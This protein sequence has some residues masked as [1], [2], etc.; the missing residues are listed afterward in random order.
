MDRATVVPR[1]DSEGEF[2]EGHRELTLRVG[3]NAGDSHRP[4]AHRRCCDCFFHVSCVDVSLCFFAHGLADQGQE[5]G[6]ACGHDHGE[7]VVTY[8]VTSGWRSATAVWVILLVFHESIDQIVA[9]PG[10]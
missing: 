5:R 9:Q 3:V 1:L 7:V 4:G 10:R 2:G 8:P 6:L